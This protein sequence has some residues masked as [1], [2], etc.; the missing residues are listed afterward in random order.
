MQ[1]HCG[2]EDMVGGE[3]FKGGRGFRH[4]EEPDNGAAGDSGFRRY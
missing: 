1:V 4:V 2:E 3:L